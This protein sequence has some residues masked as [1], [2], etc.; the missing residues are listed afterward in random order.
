[1]TLKEITHE[2]QRTEFRREL[3]W[4]VG[5]KHTSRICKALAVYCWLTKVS[6]RQFHGSTP[7]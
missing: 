6:P 4:R 7:R 3:A 5:D 1:M 2:L